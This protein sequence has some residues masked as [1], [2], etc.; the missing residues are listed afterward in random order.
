MG[1]VLGEKKLEELDRN[2]IRDYR[3]RSNRSIEHLHPQTQDGNNE[4][5]DK[6]VHRFGNL[7]MISTA[8]NSQQSNSSVGVKFGNLKDRL[9]ND[10]SL[11]NIKLLIMFKIAGGADS[12]WTENVAKDHEDKMLSLMS[13]FYSS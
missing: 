2:A 4:W 6:E 10:H 7:A 11:E 13:D 5:E 8:F 1:D 12:G 3:F 9:S